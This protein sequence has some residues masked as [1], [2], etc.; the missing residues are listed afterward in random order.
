MNTWHAQTIGAVYSDFETDSMS[1]LTA[2]DVLTRQ[3]RYGKNVF[4][5]GQQASLTRTVISQLKSPLVFILIAA[6]VATVF[7]GEYVDAFVVFLALVI[8]IGIGT[9]QEYRA[10][11]AF[12]KLAAG[13]EKHATVLR[14]GIKRVLPAYELVQGDKIFLAAGAYVPADVRLTRVRELEVNES[15][16]TGEWVAVGKQTDVLAEDTALARR[17]N[18]SWMGTLVASGSGEGVVVATGNNT[19][20]GAIAE[21]LE[22]ADERVTP[23]QKHIR[24][25]ARFLAYLTVGI[26]V[27]IF[28]LGIWRGEDISE[29]LVFAIAIAVSVIPEGLP[30]AV[31]AVLAIGMEKILSRKGLVRNLLA[32]E[33]LGSTTV[34]LT[35]KTGT[36]TQAKMALD[37]VTTYQP[38][39]H[40]KKKALEVAILASD[41][42]IEGEDTVHGRPME[43]AIIEAGIENNID[44]G[45]LLNDCP[46]IDFVPFESERRFAASLNT[47]G[48]DKKRG[49]YISGAPELTLKHADYVYEKG[50]VVPMTERHRQHFMAELKAGGEKGMRFVAVGYKETSWKDIP[51]IDTSEEIQNGLEGLVMVG[52]L[53]FVDPIR[54]DVPEAIATAQKAGARVIM[55]TGDNKE[56]ARSIAGQAGIP[57]ERVIEGKDLEALTA[58]EL[59]S[60]LEHTSVFARVLPTQKLRIV[61]TLQAQEEVVAM[62]GDGIN[63]APALRNADI[64]VAVGRGTEVAKEAS[65]L[66]LL[67]NSFSIVVAAIEEGRRIIDNLKKVIAHL[68]SKSFNLVALIAAAIVGGLP[69]PVLAAQILWINIIQEG[70]LTFAFA[71]EPAERGLMRRDPRSDD[72]KHVMTTQLKKLIMIA[73][74]VTSVVSIVIYLFLLY[75]DVPIEQIRTVLFVVLSIDAIFF[76][77]SL[78]HLRKPFWY[79]NLLGNRYLIFALGSS[80][81][82]IITTLVTPQLRNL[83]SLT[84]LEV[85]QVVLLIGVGLVNLLTIETAKYIVFHED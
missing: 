48:E 83:L 14:D 39:I 72:V 78:K 8:N 49:V 52:L 82:L 16:L 80:V 28:V 41:A 42:F 77:I 20:L 37:T 5:R 46:R 70:L 9:F 18:M 53:A 44:V 21:G 64:G 35:D 50:V 47:C 56:T 13:Q 59:R 63:D 10:S 43:K 19:Q 66:I 81:V 38:D 1:G 57:N 6:V 3:K 61:K 68:L 54:D 62:T 40:D 22:S 29:M 7:L 32:A 26:V 76:A 67:N 60:V 24:K 45:M 65:D 84:T 74:T 2:Q 36:L 85:Y 11:Q 25:L 12:D 15:A 79:A 31:T 69:L 4:I 73:G 51:P 75:A 23:I 30:A 17:T 27:L 58:T 34:I 71:F 33:T 55:V